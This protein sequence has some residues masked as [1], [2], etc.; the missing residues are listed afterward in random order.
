MIKKN[1]LGAV[2]VGMFLAS[3]SYAQDSTDQGNSSQGQGYGTEHSHR[4]PSQAAIDACSGKSVGDTCNYTNS[5]GENKSG[6]CANTS[7]QQLF[8]KR[9]RKTSS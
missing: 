7:D 6:T 2:L 4:A 5:K 3:T 1:F 9:I 8:C